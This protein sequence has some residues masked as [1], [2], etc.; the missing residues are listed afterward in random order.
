MK[1]QHIAFIADLHVFDAWKLTCTV[2]SRPESYAHLNFGCKSRFCIFKNFFFISILI[3]TAQEKEIQPG[4]PPKENSSS[5]ARVSC[6]AFRAG[7]LSIDNKEI[8]TCYPKCSPTSYWYL[9][10]SSTEGF[11][12]CEPH[13]LR[14]GCHF[15]SLR[16]DRHWIFRMDRMD[17]H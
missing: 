14:Y 15:L 5:N 6:I 7:F 1:I 11:D 3:Q 4:T 9:T 13:H 10:S 12:V 16:D 2:R 8:Y 17:C